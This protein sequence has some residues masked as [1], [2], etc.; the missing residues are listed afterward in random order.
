MLSPEKEFELMLE[1]INESEKSIP[2]DGRIHPKVGAILVD[3]HGNILERSHRGETGN[4]D[5]CE[6]ILIK[7]ATEKGINLAKSALF[8]T[9]E[10]CTSRGTGKIPC[11]RRIVESGIPKVYLG[12]LD[13]NPII[14]GRGET[15]LRDYTTLE[16]FPAELVK[17]IEES[18]K[19]FFNMFRSELLPNSS[20]YVSKQITDLMIEEM[21]R[22]GLL[23]K[24]LPTYWELT[25][26]DIIHHCQSNL[27]KVDNVYKLVIDAR[28]KAYDKKYLIIR[29][30]K[31]LVA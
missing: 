7:K 26:D 15:F 6:Y 11:A 16:R 22:S 3:L 21:Q 25:I 31:I 12:I 29:M 18:N 23:I 19:E 27:E 9:L 17:K 2:E 30:R 28:N 14:C 4:G 10:P 24:E 8:V 5:H 13:P 1:A 20:L